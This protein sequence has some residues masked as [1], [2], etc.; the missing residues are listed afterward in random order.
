VVGAVAALLG[1]DGAEAEPFAYSYDTSVVWAAGD[2]LY[3]F[4]ASLGMLPDLVVIYP[5]DGVGFD[6]GVVNAAR[7]TAIGAQFGEANADTICAAVTEVYTP[8][9]ASTFYGRM[10]WLVSADAGR[11]D[12]VVQV[13]KLWR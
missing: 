12:C 7:A 9:G 6:L 3:D 11:G 8:G 4:G 10:R 13:Y 1:V 5:Q 2:S